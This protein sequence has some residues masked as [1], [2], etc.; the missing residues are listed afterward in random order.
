M[1]KV[2]MPVRIWLES[3]YT[4]FLSWTVSI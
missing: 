4:L 3:L 2:I 1:R